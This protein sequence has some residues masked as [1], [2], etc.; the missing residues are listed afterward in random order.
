MTTYVFPEELK[1][2]KDSGVDM[3][4]EIPI[5][6]ELL[7]KTLDSLVIDGVYSRKCV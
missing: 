7:K 5:D 3:I 4:M 2:L 6:M 1:D